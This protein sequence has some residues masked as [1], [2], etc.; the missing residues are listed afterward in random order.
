MFDGGTI[1]QEWT[2]DP[3]QFADPKD[4]FSGRLTQ[5]I[6]SVNRENHILS[7]TF[8]A[9]TRAYRPLQPVF[10]KGHLVG[11]IETVHIARARALQRLAM[12]DASHKV[13][14]NPHEHVVGG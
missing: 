4:Q 6:M 14:L 7:K 9:G 1:C 5:D 10:E 13:L 8:N 2:K 12:L 3:L 11:D